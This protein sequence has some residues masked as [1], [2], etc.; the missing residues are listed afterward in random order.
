MEDGKR[1]PQA[2]GNQ[3]ISLPL[4]G[5]PEDLRIWSLELDLAA[6]VPAPVLALLDAAERA[7]M[8]RYQRHE[9]KVRFGATRAMLKRLLAGQAGGITAR[10]VGSEGVGPD[11]AACDGPASPSH[12]SMAKA[13]AHDPRAIA[14]THT[15]TGR[16][17][18][19]DS[20]M[21]FNVAHSGALALIVLSPLRPVG[22]DVEL[23][24]EVDFDAM[25]AIVLT[26]R[27]RQLLERA[28]AIAR[29]DEFYRYW[30]CKEAA[31]KATGRGIADALHRV[32]VRADTAAPDARS[33]HCQDAGMADRDLLRSLNLRILPLPGNYAGAVA[34]AAHGASRAVHGP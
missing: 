9:D 12:A 10:G 22:I 28:P 17:V 32:E 8:D 4:P 31:L 34:W 5:T 15:D 20:G 11:G 30:V 1:R 6:P 21:Y 14:F 16:P 13:S 27:E 18:W 3:A 24:K 25:A 2:G 29:R 19:P 23:R 33:I 7:R 26:A